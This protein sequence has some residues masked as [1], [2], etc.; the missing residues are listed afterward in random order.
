MNFNGKVAIVTGAGRGIAATVAMRFAEE[1]AS[2]AVCDLVLSR[3][4]DVASQIVEI[5][6]Q[7][8]AFGMDVANAA[9]VETTVRSVLDRWGRIDVLVN[10]AGGYGQRQRLTHE[11]PEEE[12]DRVINSNLKGAFLCAKYVLPTMMAARSGHIINFSSNAGR[13]LSPILGCS[14]T[15]AKTGVMGLTRHLSREYAKYGVLINT[16]APGPTAGPRNDDLHDASSMA[17]LVADMPLGRLGESREIADVVLFLASDAASFM[18][19]AILDVN[20]GY[21]L[22]P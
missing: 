21:V 8:V 22:S 12:W 5:A 15:A 9:A 10:A 17:R 14:Y 20:G 2:V 11:T 4:Q 3:A 13:T 16:I 6:G 1:G 7:A 18:T 19:G